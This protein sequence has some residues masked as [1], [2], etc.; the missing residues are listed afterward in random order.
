MNPLL[1][2]IIDV[3]TLS[4]RAGSALPDNIW[5]AVGYILLSLVGTIA[6]MSV[7]GLGLVYVERKIAAHFQCRLGPMRV[8][9]HGILQTAADALKLLSKEDILPERSDR[10]LFFLAPLLSI[11]ATI[12]ALIILPLSPSLQVIDLNIGVV[13][14]AAVSGFGVL[15]ILL[16]GWSSNNKWS[17][18]GA[19]RAGAQFVSYEISVTLALLVAVLF[20]GSLQLSEIVQSQADGWWIWRGHIVGI[21]A[22]TIFSIAS[23]AELNRPPFDLPEAESELTGGFHTEYSGLRFSF[24]FLA[25]FVNMFIGAALA[26]TLFLGGWMPFH[27]GGMDSLNAIMDII[28]PG[29]WFA[30]KTAFLI[31][32]IMWVRWTF[33]RLRVDQLMRLEWKFLLPIGFANLILAACVILTE[34]YFFPR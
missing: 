29:L 9:W 15:G 11:L 19:M 32:M 28:P 34:T 12:L 33:P 22:F 18:L 6:L 8:G 26:V 20:A 16:G 23:T 10:L 7:L 31:F 14:I 4:H 25:E 13:F 2:Q 27:I 30:G 21:V 3:V 1:A 5:L 24:F 17:L